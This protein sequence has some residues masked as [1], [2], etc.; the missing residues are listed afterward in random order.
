MGKLRLEG[1]IRASL[2]NLSKQRGSLCSYCVV[3]RSR[4]L[5]APP[6]GQSSVHWSLCRTLGTW[7]HQGQWKVDRLSPGTPGLAHPDPPSTAGETEG[8]REGHRLCNAVRW[9][10]LTG[11]TSGSRLSFPT[12]V[13]IGSQGGKAGKMQQLDAAVG[14]G[15][16]V[17][18]RQPW[19]GAA[20]PESS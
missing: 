20:V 13:K 6:S 2:P 5:S 17:G 4:S 3:H 14:P 7:G 8:Q 10:R 11:M 1:G 18:S 15:C 9:G 16:L 19:A 12:I